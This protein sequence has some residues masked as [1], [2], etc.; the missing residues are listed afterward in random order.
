MFLYNGIIHLFILLVAYWNH[1]LHW[2]SSLPPPIAPRALAA[3]REAERVKREGSDAF[4][5]QRAAG[6][7]D[8]SNARKVD[9]S[10]DYYAT[11]GVDR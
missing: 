11:L 8:S 9:A 2:H 10:R 7:G 3:K 5:A 6:D 4:V 1:V